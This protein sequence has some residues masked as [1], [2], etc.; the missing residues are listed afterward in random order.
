VLVGVVENATNS[1]IV[2]I[3]GYAMPPLYQFNPRIVV[4]GVFG[5]PENPTELERVPPLM[6]AV[7]VDPLNNP[8]NT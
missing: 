5:V 2:P 3:H 7:T 8:V 6:S 4:A 1:L